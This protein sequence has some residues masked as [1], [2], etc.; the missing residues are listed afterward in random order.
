MSEDKYGKDL[1]GCLCSRCLGHHRRLCRSCPRPPVQPHLQPHPSHSQSSSYTKLLATPQYTPPDL[2][3]LLPL[4]PLPGIFLVILKAL[5]HSL[6]LHKVFLAPT[7]P[8]AQ[9]S[10]LPWASVLPA[11]ID[12][13]TTQGSQQLSQDK[14]LVTPGSA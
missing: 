14:F 9:F 1:G 2:H 3:I 5:L 10:I 12:L 4:P 11:N 7:P 8:L 6:L 13:F